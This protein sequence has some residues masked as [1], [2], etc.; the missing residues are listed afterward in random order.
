MALANSR[1]MESALLVA[2]FPA[3]DTW[4]LQLLGVVS[5]FCGME[6]TKMQYLSHEEFI[7]EDGINTNSFLYDKRVKLVP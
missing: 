3:W 4:S 2:A 6:K 7:M 5:A 1:A